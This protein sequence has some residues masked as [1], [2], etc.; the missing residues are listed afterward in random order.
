MRKFLFITILLAGLGCNSQK[1]SLKT[2]TYNP[3]TDTLKIVGEKHLRNVKQ[4]TFGGDNAEAYWSFNSKFLSF[5]ATNMEW[6]TSCDQIYF[7][8]IKNGVAKGTVAPLI[9]TGKGRTTCAYF[10]PGDSLILYASTHAADPGCLEAPRIM[11]GKYVWAVFNQYDIYV[12]NLKGEIRKRL[13]SSDGYDAE[14]TIS[15]DGKK[16]IFTSTRSGD[17]ELWT[18]NVDGSGLK[19]ITNE[20]GYDG[21]AFFSNDSKYIVWRASRPK[22][23][24]DVD[25][26]KG[27]L[28][29]GLV[30]PTNMELFIANADGTNQRQLTHLGGANWAPYFTP[31]NKSILFSSNHHNESRRVFNIFKINVDGTGLEQITK[32]GIFDSFPM[33]S[34]DGK[35][36]SWS[37][38]RNNKGTRD[39]NVFLAEWVSEPKE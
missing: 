26:Y 3:T 30:Q 31:D 23:Q 19:Q 16:I 32:D 2:A 14:A 38:N 5:Q 21:G 20:L 24:D 13:T 12:A 8:D 10:M 37:S 11:G 25:T 6:G 36:I 4:L 28:K 22:N 15:P 17:L 7:M 1:H 34:R 9:S 18:M 39:T 29:Q 33:F 27:L 35:Y